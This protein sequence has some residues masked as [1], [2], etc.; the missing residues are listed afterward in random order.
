MMGV[1]PGSS[2]SHWFHIQFMDVTVGLSW[3]ASQSGTHHPSIGDPL[4]FPCP[5]RFHFSF[6][7]LVDETEGWSQ[8]SEVVGL[9]MVELMALPFPWFKEAAQT[10][11]ELPSSL[12]CCRHS[13]ALILG[14]SLN[15]PRDLFSN[16]KINP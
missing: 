5:S 15:L 11:G 1:V 10:R 13:C 3:S 2:L 9:W 16:E 14:Q 8:L 7:L 6:S 4:P 12:A